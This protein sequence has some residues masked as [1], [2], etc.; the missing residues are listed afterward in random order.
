MHIGNI[1]SVIIFEKKTNIN[2]DLI[3]LPV[4]FVLKLYIQFIIL[5]VLIMFNNH[6][7]YWILIIKKCIMVPGK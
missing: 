7:W 5:N 1:K 2:D 3:V 6:I 4:I